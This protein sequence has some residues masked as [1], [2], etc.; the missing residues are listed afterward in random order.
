MKRGDE[1]MANKSEKGNGK[2]FVWDMPTRLFHWTLAILVTTSILTGLGWSG[3]TNEAWV[4]EWSGISILVLLFF[5]IFW[6]LFGGRHARFSDF[7]KGPR[8]VFSYAKGLVTGRHEQWKGHNPMGGLA[9]IALIGLLSAQVGTGLF[10]NDDSDIEGPLFDKV[11]KEISDV[12]TSFH[13]DI[14]TLI[15]IVIG[16]HVT[17]IVLYRFQ[18]ERLIAAMMHGHKEE[19]DYKES[20]IKVP[21]AGNPFLAL[22]VLAVSVGLVAF[23]LNI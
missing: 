1:D 21:T 16:V 17:A 5:R 15:F 12:I 11:G 22:V 10:A 7:I 9:V 19:G 8:A 18:G 13:Y 6:G 14:A 23:I 2:I 4:H 3:L 20:A